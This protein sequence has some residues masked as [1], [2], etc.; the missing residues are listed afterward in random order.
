MIVGVLSFV[1]PPSTP[2]TFSLNLPPLTSSI[3]AVI[4]TVPA[5]VS[6]FEYAPL[7]QFSFPARSVAFATISCFPSGIG[8]A[9]LSVHSPLSFAFV[10]PML[11][12][13][14]KSSTVALASALP[15]NVGLLSFV[16]SSL[17]SSWNLPPSLLSMIASIVGLGVTVSTISLASAL[18]GLL[19]ITFTATAVMLCSPSGRVTLP[20]GVKLHL[21]SLSAL[22]SPI[23]LPLS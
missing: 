22:V 4:S 8:S 12:P 21:P 6:T 7:D 23:L 9:G 1:K 10:V 19:P 18:A 11:L 20:F 13:L 17:T 14:S 16:T 3:T 5:S 15:L 2:R